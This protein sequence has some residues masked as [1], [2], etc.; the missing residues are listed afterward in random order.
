VSL[1][2]L[3]VLEDP[4]LDKF[5]AIPIVERI[6]R[7]LGKPNARVSAL[8]NPRV[9]GHA[10]AYEIVA[11]DLEDYRQSHAIWIFLQDADC[12]R[13][14]PYLREKVAQT[15]VK[16]ASVAIH[17]ELEIWLLAGF[18]STQDFGL[19]Q[20]VREH[21]R[22]KEEVFAPFMRSRNVNESVGAGRKELM[23][24]AMK[25]WNTVKTR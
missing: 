6:F 3:V 23:R 2:V 14:V 5:I 24:E 18:A 10:Q 12:A 16:L 19:W 13:D 22:L 7:D 4:H 15:G 20:Q 21:P 11:T 9:R 25:N 8:E 17:P 1:N